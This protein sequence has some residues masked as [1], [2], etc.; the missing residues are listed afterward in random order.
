[1]YA[2][3]IS[4]D[5]TISEKTLLLLG[6]V[7]RIPFIENTIW[8]KAT[9]GSGAGGFGDA[10]RKCRTTASPASTCG[11][12]IYWSSSAACWRSA[13]AAARRGGIE[14]EGPGPGPGPEPDPDPGPTSEFWPNAIFGIKEPEGV[15]LG[16]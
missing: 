10:A 1:M 5:E 13:E 15:L 2:F 4:T 6:Y 8:S 14:D 12:A 3:I 9:L 16:L 7:G 11:L